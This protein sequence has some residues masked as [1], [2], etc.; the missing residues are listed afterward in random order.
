[1]YKSIDSYKYFLKYTYL[2]RKIRHGKLP[3]HHYLFRFCFGSVLGTTRFGPTDGSIEYP[4]I[5]LMN[6]SP[7]RCLASAAVLGHW[8]RPS[9]SRMYNKTYR[10][11]VH[12]NPLIRSSLV[13]QNRNK[14]SFSNGSMPYFRLINVDKPSIP[15]RRSD[16]PTASTIFEKVTP[17]LVNML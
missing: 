14:V 15:L 5:S 13:P 9:A 12:N 4:S 1:M 16:L 7:V 6:S 3:C 8:K 10:S 2:S 11:P 17:S